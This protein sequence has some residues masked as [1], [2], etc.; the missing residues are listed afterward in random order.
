M[1]H[2]F[3]L[4]LVLDLGS[5]PLVSVET[6]KRINKASTTDC[7]RY[8]TKIGVDKDGKERARCNGCNKIC[9]WWKKIWNFS[10]ESSMKCDKTKSE[11]IGQMMLELRGKLKGKKIDQS[12]HCQLFIALVLM[13]HDLI[14]CSVLMLS[15]AL[16]QDLIYCTLM[17]LQDSFDCT[18]FMLY[19]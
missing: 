15:V 13:L 5:S 2:L 10:F 6:N 7:W 4:N 1:A 11:D 8:V 9:V 12:E 14:L 18:V 19:D 16:V 3:L 17:M